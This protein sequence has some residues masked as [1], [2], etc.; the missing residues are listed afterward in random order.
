MGSDWR[1]SVVLIVSADPLINR[2]GTGFV[3]YHDEQ[4]D[5]VLTCEHVVRDVGGPDK[6]ESGGVAGALVASGAALGVDIAVLRFKSLGYR[7]TL[8][9]RAGGEKEALFVTAGFQLFDK[10]YLIRTLRGTLG[11]PS[12]LESRGRQSRV[13]AW[14][15]QITAAYGL[16][17]GYSGSPV[18]DER[19]GCA[20]AVVSHR[21]AA[22]EKGLAISVKMLES[23]WPDVP[24]RLF[25]PPA[26]RND[27]SIDGRISGDRLEKLQLYVR[28]E[29]WL[30][31]DQR[32]QLEQVLGQLLPSVRLKNLVGPAIDSVLAADDGLLF[33]RANLATGWRP[34][35]IK[36][37]FGSPVRLPPDL[38]DIAEAHRD[39][40]SYPNNTKYTI[41][42]IAAP[43]TDRT[44]DGIL[45][46]IHLAPIS[47]FTIHGL[48]LGLDDVLDGVPGVSIRQKL[49]NDHLLFTATNRLPNKVVVHI[50]V[51]TGDGKMLLMQRSRYVK[52]QNA[53]WSATFEE[54][55]QGDSFDETTG[56][57]VRGDQDFF[58]TAVRGVRE[59]LGMEID[60]HSITFLGIS[61]EYE[62]LAYNVVGVAMLDAYA[63]AIISSWKLNAPDIAEHSR[64]VAIPFNP[65]E[66]S[67]LIGLNRLHLP[68][69]NVHGDKWHPTSRL[70]IFL[71]C[72]HFLSIAKGRLDA[73]AAD[74][75]RAPLFARKDLRPS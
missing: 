24:R 62:N 3:I 10:D 34:G 68:D 4:G 70:R 48:E 5:Y 44:A 35:S 49:F 39:E 2:F 8:P 21:E 67:R 15:L 40:L 69:H 7:P 22:G 9:L 55:M 30:E 60:R 53:Q 6:V 33:L 26:K 20:V 45:I 58:A 1:D 66:V 65:K 12:G 73:E 19:N 43:I 25:E 46:T 71:T 51:V 29:P 47:Y 64:I 57:V 36:L 37:M 41:E 14:D 31:P 59:E 13:E 42:W 56:A 54:Q 17:P 11:E 23:V 63:D 18:I 16:Q 75:N 50:L 38:K 32:R 28:S 72:L 61:S 52:F 27:I 74:N